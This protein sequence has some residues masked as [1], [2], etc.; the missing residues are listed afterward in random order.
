MPANL[1]KVVV[2]PQYKPS[3]GFSFGLP[4]GWAYEIIYSDE[5][6]ESTS[7]I[8]RPETVE[9]GRE[10]IIQYSR[11]FGVCGTGLRMEQIDFNG[12]E[13]AMGFYDGSPLWSFIV[14]SGEY[15][16]CVILN[17]GHNWYEEHE[18]EI[19]LLLCSVKFTY[20]E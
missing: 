6:P 9:A 18:D 1:T 10:I 13:A 8:V 17:F 16:N 19:D 11:S 14:L 15:K 4:E 20:Y 7:A 12:H 2:E 5:E 3:M